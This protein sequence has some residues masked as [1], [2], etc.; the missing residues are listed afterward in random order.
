MAARGGAAGSGEVVADD[1]EVVEG[2][3]GE[4]GAPAQSP[5]AQMPGAVVSRRSLTLKWPAGVVLMP[6]SSRPMFCVL[7]VRPVAT[8]RWEPSR[9]GLPSVR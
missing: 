9:M 5:M 1:A 6:A 3:V 4:V 2:D 7:G 8:R